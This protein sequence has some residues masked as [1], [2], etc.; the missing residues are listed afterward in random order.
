M[1]DQEIDGNNNIQVLGNNNKITVYHRK[2]SIKKVITPPPGS[3]SS[4]KSKVIKDLVST[5]GE[6]LP[7]KYQGAYNMLY[8][9][10]KITTYKELP[11]SE[12][13]NAVRWL[14]SMIAAYRKKLKKTDPI[15]YRKELYRAIHAKSRELSLT[16][17]HLFA[18]EKLNLKKPIYSLTEL[19]D[20]RLQKLHDIL[21]SIK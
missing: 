10:F 9:K 15:S 18:E 4:E 8:N 12:F 19:S 13:E 16:D 2:P 21:F 17:I 1:T 7:N 6:R 20:S 14:S 5:L 3:I 11:D